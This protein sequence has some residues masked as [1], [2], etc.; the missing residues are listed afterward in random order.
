[1]MERLRFTE[2][3]FVEALYAKA[4]SYYIGADLF[5]DPNGKR[6]R[7]DIVSDPLFR[8]IE[9]HRRITIAVRELRKFLAGSPREFRKTFQALRRGRDKRYSRRLAH[10]YLR[11]VGAGDLVALRRLVKLSELH[12]TRMMRVSDRE[13]C[14]PVSWHYYT[15][16]GAIKFLARGVVPTKKAVKDAAIEARARAELSPNASAAMLDT[17]KLQLQRLAPRRWRRIF[18]DLE[19]AKLPTA[20]RQA[21]LASGPSGHSTLK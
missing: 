21:K 18:N 12:E 15:G 10:E 20:K 5:R 17:K 19:L 2:P 8:A 3:S 7:K 6:I 9:H 14:N 16:I 1:M 11:A 13:T 4:L